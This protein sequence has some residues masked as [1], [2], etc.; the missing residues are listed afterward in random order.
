MSPKKKAVETLK[1]KRKY[2]VKGKPQSE[3]NETRLYQAQ[4]KI[5]KMMMDKR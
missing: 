2:G 4:L 3:E 1:N 5:Y